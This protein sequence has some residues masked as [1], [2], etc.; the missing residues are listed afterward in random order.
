MR[1]L[2]SLIMLQDID[3]RR[4]HI[5]YGV[6]NLT[7]RSQREQALVNHAALESQRLQL[8]TAVGA[9]EERQ[10][11]HEDEAARLAEK[12]TV[13]T[14]RLYDGTITSPKEAAALTHE[15]ETLQQHQRTE[16]DA[17]LELM[18]QAEPV[19]NQ[20]DELVRRQTEIGEQ[21][22]AW[23][24]EIRVAEAAATD[25]DDKA[26]AERS[27]LAATIGSELLALYE[28]YRT[29]QGEQPAVGVLESGTC[30]ACHLSLATGARDRISALDPDDPADCPECGALLVRP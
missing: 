27:E 8:V 2:G 16:E 25:Q 13:D 1:K 22:E 28:Q 4:Q 5:R 26:V 3:L 18:E 11:V 10:A 12:A 29:R 23:D 21:I 14:Q 17:V 9:V 30:S 15:I 20:M 6:D 19:Q 24:E 7:Q